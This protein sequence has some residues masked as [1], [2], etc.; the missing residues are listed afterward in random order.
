MSSSISSSDSAA[1]R[2][3]LRLFIGLVAFLLLGILALFL[4]LDPY[5]TGRLTP[6]DRPVMYETGPR[7][8]HASRTRDDA[9]DAAII[10]NSTIQLLSPDRLNGATGQRFVQ[11]SVPGTG[12]REHVAVIEHLLW[13]RG[14]GLKTLVLGLGYAWCDPR[15]AVVTANPFPFWLYDTNP[16]TYAS[17]LFR[18]DTLEALP[19]R[20]R[21]LMGREKQSRKDGYWDYELIP[22]GYQKFA[23]RDLKV[24]DL[25]MPAGP[26][27]SAART[28]ESL[29]VSLPAGLQV[30]LVHPPV[31][32]PHPPQMSLQGRAAMMACK[33]EIVA[34]IAKRPGTQM[35]D[36][37]VDDENT[38]TRT[39]FFDHDHYRS[40]MAKIL[41]SRIAELIVN[42][43]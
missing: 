43:R 17:G 9:F 27:K 10:G 39:L 24:P 21:L 7:M 42:G 34:A 31:F 29:L 8:A 25:A 19:R 30:I 35:L 20:I 15:R 4:T 18:M 33:A 16:V 41:E 38:R 1:P 22:E 28:L 12:P 36:A 14:S 32:S 2:G 5:G 40:G 26:Q 6:F 13:R 11:L 23:T 37:W 3:F